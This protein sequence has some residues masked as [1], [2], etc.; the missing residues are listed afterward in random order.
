MQGSVE[1]DLEQRVVREG[2]GVGG[3]V[4]CLNQIPELVLALRV[5]SPLV[6]KSFLY[7]IQVSF[8]EPPSKRLQV[9]TRLALSYDG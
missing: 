7:T 8:L 9:L 5:N 4:G 2:E 6:G 3:R 1:Q